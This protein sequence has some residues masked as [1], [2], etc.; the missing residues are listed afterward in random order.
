AVRSDAGLEQMV[1]DQ[2]WID[3]ECKYDIAA[4]SVQGVHVRYSEAFEDKEDLQSLESFV[5]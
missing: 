2:F 5:G 4:I 3:E 1:P